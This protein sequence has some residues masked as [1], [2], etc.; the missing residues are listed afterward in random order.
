[1]TDEAW[2]YVVNAKAVKRIQEEQ[3]AGQRD[4]YCSGEGSMKKDTIAILDADWVE[5]APRLRR[6]GPI[7]AHRAV[8]SERHAA[9]RRDEQVGAELG[10][11]PRE[12]QLVRPFSGVQLVGV[13]FVFA[14]QLV[15]FQ[16]VVPTRDWR[17]LRH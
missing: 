4:R 3:R 16:H 6:L 10:Q 13:F 5:M 14:C 12:R 15:F 9:E 2:V 1:M 8:R 11:D 7:G 17:I